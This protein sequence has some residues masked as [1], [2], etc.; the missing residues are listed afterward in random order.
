MAKKI[1]KV[2]RKP[3][4]LGNFQ[5]V[6]HE[7]LDRVVNG[8]IGPEGKLTG[9]LGKDA[10]DAEIIVGYDKLGGLILSKDG[11]KVAPGS[12]YD[13]DRGEARKEF[14]PKPAKAPAVGGVRVKNVGDKPKNV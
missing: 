6:N 7:K 12:F 11:K 14:A 9:G 10:T 5:L 8:F 3:V 2:V 13:F 4:K 1:E